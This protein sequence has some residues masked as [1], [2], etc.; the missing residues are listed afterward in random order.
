MGCARCHNHKYDP[1]PQRDYY[2]LSAILQAAY[3]PYE[4]KAPRDR[5]Y[6]I[7]LEGEIKAAVEHNTPIQAEIKKLQARIDALAE[8]F[9]KAGETGPTGDLEKK[10][11]ELAAQTKSLRAELQAIREKLQ[12]QPH[13]RILTDNEEPSVSYLLKRGDPVGFGDPVEPGVPTVIQNVALKAYAPTSPFPG[14]SGRRL[15][16]ARWLTQ[17]NHPR[18]AR[19]AV[20]QI[21]SRHFGRGIVASVSNFGRSGVPPSHPELL[22]WLATEFVA[23][24]WS[25]K[26]LHRSIVTSQAYRQTSQVDAATLAADP[27]NVLLS[28]MPLRRMDAETLYDSMITVVS[29]LDPAMFGAPAAIDIRPDKEVVVKPTAAGFRRAIYVLHRRQTPVSLLDAFDQPPMTP[30]CTERRRSNVATQALHMM[31]GSM[32]WDLARYMAGHV[33][34]E[35]GP[36]SARQVEAVYQRAYAR[37]PTPAESDVGVTAI[38]EFMKQWPARLAADNSDAPRAAN[39]QWLGLANYCHAILN[40]AEFSFI[41]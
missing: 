34:D 4:W 14:A 41:D 20:N 29:R 38:A 40:S 19:V 25:M 5:E 21:W 27:D 33:I 3:N 26:Q 10:Y 16:L 23:R 12:P 31:N 22:D 7:G 6:H 9:R 37:R 28:R 30:N 17:P 15:A 39:A 24:G 2:R 35:V 1:I 8:S 11:P 13:I 32:S 18:T 36:D